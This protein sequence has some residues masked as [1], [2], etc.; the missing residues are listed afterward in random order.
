MS[1]HTRPPTPTAASQ[2]GNTATAPPCSSRPSRSG[3]EK[4]GYFPRWK[5][6][7]QARQARQAIRTHAHTPAGQHNASAGT[8]TAHPHQLHTPGKATH[9]PAGKHTPPAPSA[10]GKLPAPAKQNAHAQHRP[11]AGDST[12]HAHAPGSIRPR[13]RA[14]RYCARGIFILRVAAPKILVGLG[15]K[16]HFPRPWAAY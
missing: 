11:P 16:N 13:P 15:P 5:Q 3:P 1:R 12:R 7:P 10:S 14:K 6:I 2:T 8:Q 4:A 9:P